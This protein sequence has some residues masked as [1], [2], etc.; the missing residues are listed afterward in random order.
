VRTSYD[1]GRALVAA[2]ASTTEPIA[3]IGDVH[4]H[5]DALERLLG[6]IARQHP[7]ARLAF[8][9]DLGHKGPDSVGTY[10]RILDLVDAGD[11]AVVASNHGAA[12]ARHLGRLLDR[13]YNVVEAALT[14]YRQA[15]PLASHATLRQVAQLAGA[16]AGAADGDE[17]AER[18]V[19]LQRNVPLQLTLDD[20]AAV[21]VH[22]GLTPDT[23]GASGRRAQQVCLYG[24]G[25]GRDET[26]RA[27]GRDSW[28]AG[29][30]EAREQERQLPFVFYGHITYPRPLLTDHTCGIDTGCG[31]DDPK[32]TL[33][34]A[35]WSGAQ[36]PIRLLGVSAAWS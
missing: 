20:G 3:V 14:L 21:V 1:Y 2:P 29:W 4:G 28:V 26:G 25:S 34:A 24:T 23:F 22:G 7:N 6:D 15:E 13:G 17:L 35:V 31:P 8:V 5:L 16:L 19:A 36:Q 12:D 32:A 18:I 11:A 27:I 33:S 10:R 9:G 30:C